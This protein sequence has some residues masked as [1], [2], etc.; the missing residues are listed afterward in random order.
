MKFNGIPLLLLEHQGNLKIK[1][2]DK[3]QPKDDQTT[4]FNGFTTKIQRFTT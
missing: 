4:T 1:I 3:I 2:L